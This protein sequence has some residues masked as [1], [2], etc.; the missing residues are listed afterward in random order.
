VTPGKFLAFFVFTA[1]F[2]PLSIVPPLPVCRP[3][4]H[5]SV[6]VYHFFASRQS[7]PPALVTSSRTE[8]YTRVRRAT[9]YSDASG[10]S[11]IVSSGKENRRHGSRAGVD[12]PRTPDKSQG[13]TMSARTTQNNK[14]PE[15]FAGNIP[16]TPKMSQKPR[17]RPNGP[18]AK[19]PARQRERG[20]RGRWSPLS[21][22]IPVHQAVRSPALQCQ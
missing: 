7:A 8:P 3:C 12:A 21:L 17:L 16:D 19:Q 4:R 2:P 9:A 6:A 20:R 22:L 10:T 15:L 14:R 11:L 5:I 18:R 13:V 1:A